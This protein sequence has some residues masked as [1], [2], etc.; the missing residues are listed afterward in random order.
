VTVSPALSAPAPLELKLAVQF[1]V[2]PTTVESA[3]KDTEPTVV[4]VATIVNPEAGVTTALASSEVSTPSV[5]V[6]TLPGVEFVMPA[7][8]TV[9]ALVSASAQVP[10]SVIFTTWAVVE[11]VVVPVHVPA[12][13]DAK[14]T[15]GDA[16]TLKPL[17]TVTEIVSPAPSAPFDD[18][19]N[20]TV[21][22][23]V[24]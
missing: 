19:V 11:P 14:V 8:V 17:G 20:P 4:P 18:E 22:V 21:H 24:A 16:G 23:E 5:L 13:P 2:V 10:L 7:M 1:V 12:K 9:A 15:V 3:V 6:V